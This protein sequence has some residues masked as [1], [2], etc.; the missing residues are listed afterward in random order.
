MWISICDRMPT[1]TKTAN[2]KVKIT[3]GSFATKSI[4]STV[5]GR[6]TLTGYRFIVSDWQQVTH[7]WDNGN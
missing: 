5:R 7:W 6:L 3:E 4:V 1:N 2:V